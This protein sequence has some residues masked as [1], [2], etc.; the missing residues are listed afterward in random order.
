MRIVGYVCDSSLNKQLDKIEQIAGRCSLV[1][2][3]VYAYK[4]NTKL[5]VLKSAPATDE[6][7][8]SFHSTDFIQRLKDANDVTDIEKYEDSLEEYG[9]GYDCPLF[10]GIYDFVRA[11]VGSSIVA[12]RS[13][14]SG[15]NNIAINWYGGWHHAQREEAKGFCY[16]NDIVCAINT[17]RQHFTRVLYIDLDIHH[18]DGVEN[19]FAFSRNVLT[20]SLHKY[21]AGFYPGSGAITDVGRGNGRFYS[22]NV[23]LHDGIR[24]EPY[25][26]IFDRVSSSIHTAFQPDAI[27]VQCGC[28]SLCGDP[29]GTF[30]LTLKGMGQCVRRILSWEKPTLFLGGGGYNI[31][32]AARCWTYITSLILNCNLS[33]EIPD[34]HFF[35]KYGPGFE[36]DIMQGNRPDHNTEQYIESCI[37]TITGNIANIRK[38]CWT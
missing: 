20:F 17:L 16:A 15:S 25:F 1:N 34:N 27:V 13:L 2:H 11:I 18:G 3:L 31:T 21:E 30:N 14:I 38:P 8:L 5:S 23:P 32:N 12:A 24:D 19:A 37:K 26:K 7:I 35:E 10:L 22:V 6:E 33:S 28:D 36:L 9:L 29:L 4:L